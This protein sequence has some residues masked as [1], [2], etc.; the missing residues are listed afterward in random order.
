MPQDTYG[1][2]YQRTEVIGLENGASTILTAPID[3][4]LRLCSVGFYATAYA[5]DSVYL[6]LVLLPPN[7]Q[8][9]NTTGISLGESPLASTTGFYVVV[10][11]QAQT[12]AIG[13]ANGGCIYPLNKWFSSGG[14][15][16]IIPPAWSL[17]VWFTNADPASNTYEIYAVG[18]PCNA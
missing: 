4:C 7:A 17:A 12:G 15:A 13:V 5:T 9:P 3:S 18:V 10:A 2:I 16:I 14:G 8:P 11:G 6:N 1:T